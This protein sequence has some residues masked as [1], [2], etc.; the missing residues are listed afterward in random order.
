MEEL[1]SPAVDS[2]VRAQT[3]RTMAM[4]GHTADAD[5]LTERIVDVAMAK[6]RITMCARHGDW[7]YNIWNDEQRPLGF[8][9]R[10]PWDAW[11]ESQPRWETVLDIDALDLNRRDGDDIRW[12]LVDF[13]LIYPTYDRALVRLSPSGSDACIVREFDVESRTFVKNG[14]ELP[15]P[16]HHRVAWIDR[17]TVYVG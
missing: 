5:A 10:T 9:R 11:V 2:W 16:G 8:I 14:F 4:Y 3:D 6:D 12:V 13:A 7:G 1:G 17:D 15:E